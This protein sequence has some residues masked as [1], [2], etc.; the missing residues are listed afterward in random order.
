MADDSLSDGR[1][2]EPQYDKKENEFPDPYD[3]RD[4]RD[5][6]ARLIKVIDALTAWTAPLAPEHAEK[7]DSLRHHLQVLNEPPE[8]FDPEA[9]ADEFRAPMNDWS[10]EEMFA[11]L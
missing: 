2:L 3:F 5:S 1:S 10:I 8:E 11:D 4:W 9:D 6:S 7:V